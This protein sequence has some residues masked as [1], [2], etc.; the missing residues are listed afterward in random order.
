LLDALFNSERTYPV[1]LLKII[2]TAG[3]ATMRKRLLALTAA[4]VIAAGS[5]TTPTPARA[6]GPALVV[7]I[8]VVAVIATI[9]T[10]NALEQQ[11]QKPVRHKRK[12]R[13]S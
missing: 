9:V 8:V 13:H 2:E 11:Q 12:H 4:T 10:V 3:E 1:A 5:I 7:A 6:A